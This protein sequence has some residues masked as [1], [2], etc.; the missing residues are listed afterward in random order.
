MLRTTIPK[1]VS[2]A[3]FTQERPFTSTAIHAENTPFERKVQREYS[4]AELF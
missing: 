1:C 3:A 2:D 4:F